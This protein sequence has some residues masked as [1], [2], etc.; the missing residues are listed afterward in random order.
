MAATPTPQEKKI[1]SI[2]N[3][4]AL[5]RALQYEAFSTEITRHVCY[6]VVGVDGVIHI[7]TTIAVAGHNVSKIGK[8]RSD[9]DVASKLQTLA[10][11]MG[12]V[13][14]PIDKYT[15]T[16]NRM[17]IAFGPLYASIRKILSER[18]LL[19]ISVTTTTHPALCDLGFNGF[20]HKANYAQSSDYINKFS[21]VIAKATQQDYDASV[22][23]DNI[24][25]FRQI[26][27]DG[28]RKDPSLDKWLDLDPISTPFKTMVNLFIDDSETEIV[29][30]VD[31]RIDRLATVPAGVIAEISKIE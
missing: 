12:V 18:N 17:V 31:D 30:V 14:R 9:M 13:G 28:L 16:F 11:K 20:R 22:T 7:L 3:I 15:I 25:K 5:G 23:T 21:H 27:Q 8:N 19:P 6:K 4:L 10:G 26:G 29:N 24:E 1:I 2:D